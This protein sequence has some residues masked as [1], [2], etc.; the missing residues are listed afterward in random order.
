MHTD[1]GDIVALY[2]LSRS[3]EGGRFYLADIQN[4]FNEMVLTRPDLATTLIDD[5]V[6]MEYVT[7]PIS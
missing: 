3:V 5:W 7:D 4:V 1:K 6:Q 2:T